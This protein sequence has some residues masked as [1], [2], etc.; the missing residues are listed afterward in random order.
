MPLSFIPRGLFKPQSSSLPQSQFS[1][2]PVMSRPTSFFSRL[3]SRCSYYGL[4]GAET[5]TQPASSLKA[6]S[7]MHNLNISWATAFMT[8][9]DPICS[10]V[11]ESSR[12]PTG[13]L[14][15]FIV[16]HIVVQGGPEI[17]FLEVVPSHL[18]IH[19]LGPREVTQQLRSLA[20]LPERT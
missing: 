3:L 2:G 10:Q 18:K 11:R 14:P 20:A 6:C 13:I 4:D 16:Q 12:E 19:I 8:R 5:P 9:Q 1:P 17:K 7:Q 15:L